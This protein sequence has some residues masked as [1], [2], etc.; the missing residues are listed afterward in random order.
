MAK[1]KRIAVRKHY[2][3]NGTI[4]YLEKGRKGEK[5]SLLTKKGKLVKK[6][7]VKKNGKFDI[8]LTKKEAKKLA[9]GEKYFLLKAKDKGYKTFE[10]K[11]KLY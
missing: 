10:I 8:R 3:K 2:R 6:F 7:T 1:A 4:L 9:K 11:V 5:I